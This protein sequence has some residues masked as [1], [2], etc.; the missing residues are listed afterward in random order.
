MSGALSVKAH[1]LPFSEIPHTT[2]LFTD[3]LA[4]APKVHAY[5]PRPPLFSEWLKEEGASMQYDSSRRERVTGVLERQNKSFSRDGNASPQAQKNLDR[6]RKGAAAVVTGQQVGLFGGPMF[7]IYKALTAVKLAEEA[8]SA[9]VDT[10]PIFWLATYDH[11]LAEV[12]HISIPGAEGALQVLTITSHDLPG[13]PVSAVRLGDEVVSAVEQAAG[14]LG[15]SEA[16]QFL[17]ESYRPG[18]TMGTAFARLFA[19]IFAEWGVILLD[20]S[21]PELARI[22]EPIYRAAIDKSEALVDAL[23]ARGHALEAAGYR[24]QVK[25]TESSVLLFMTRDGV[26][27]P[28]HRRGK[29]ETAEFVVGS[30]N[31]EVKFSRDQLNAELSSHP[32]YFSPNVLLRPVVQDYLL[33]TLA[34]T[35]GAAETAYFAQAGV[36]YEA[37]VGRITPVVPRF[38]ATIV[39]PKMQRLL[40]K[41]SIALTEVFHGCEELRRLIAAR[42]LP[43]D[44]KAAFETAQNSFDSNLSS[45]KEK[46][47]RLDRTLVDA[48]ETARSKM[49]HQLE[50]LYSQAARAEALKG[51]LF[52]RHAETLSHAL[53]PEKSLQERGVGGIYFLARYGPGLLHELYGA[54]HS[55]CPDHQILEL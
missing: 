26:R 42:S 25:V 51:E 53:Y 5:Y 17:R 37:L 28:I 34:Y 11:D 22:A 1:C 48:A 10:V 45:I 21:D 16:V 46:L 3:F 7:S 19:R 13:A 40:E 18:E 39:E 14:L 47:E 33:P 4:Y 2:R 24:Q 27:Q 6:L 50:K 49:H 35:G 43:E 44:L 30:E 15:E 12:N 32:E 38:S 8:T 31:S 41:H 9:G 52:A 29:G 54:M 23:L 55:D 36:V 20:A